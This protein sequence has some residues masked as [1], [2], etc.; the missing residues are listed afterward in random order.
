[1]PRLEDVGE[2]HATFKLYNFG[3]SVLGELDSSAARYLR[4]RKKILSDGLDS[5]LLQLFLEGGVRFG[6]GTQTTYAEKG[7]IVVFDLNRPVDNFNT[8]FKHLTMMM[9]REMMDAAIPNISRWHGHVLPHQNPAARLLRDLMISSF[10]MAPRFDT[11]AG[12]HVESATVAL[13]A[14]AMSGNATFAE[15]AVDEDVESVLTYQIKRHIRTHLGSED[16]TPEALA[17][18][19][20]VSRSQIYRLMEPLGGVASYVR[21]LRL[22]R[23]M[24]E[25]GDPRFAHL[26]VSEIAY[27]SGFTHLTTFNRSFRETFGMTPSEAREK[28]RHAHLSALSEKN[29]RFR[30]NPVLR[31]HEWFRQIGS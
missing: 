10:E 4:S 1:M 30:R 13:A 24:N 26:N 15:G 17:K 14:A 25:L 16:L 11:E 23:C 7:D 22:Q 5:I 2:F 21:Q 28:N 19:F 12:R 3:Q 29:E 27:R 18:A 9:P 31:H 6:S 8:T 20:G